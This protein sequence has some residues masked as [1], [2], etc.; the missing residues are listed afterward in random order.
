[1]NGHLIVSV[2]FALTLVSHIT[3]AA[4]LTKVNDTKVIT[5][6]TST[7]QSIDSSSEADDLYYDI[8]EEKD[9]LVAEKEFITI[10]CINSALNG[11]SP[12]ITSTAGVSKMQTVSDLKEWYCSLNTSVDVNYRKLQKINSVCRNEISEDL[13]TLVSDCESQEDS[14]LTHVDICEK[15]N[16]ET[17]KTRFAVINCTVQV[18][19]NDGVECIKRTLKV[20][21]VPNNHTVFADW[22]C[23]TYNA[24]SQYTF[25]VAYTEECD[26][27][28]E[29]FIDK[30]E[31][32]A[33]KY[34]QQSH[35]DDD[36]DD[37]ANDEPIAIE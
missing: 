6:T 9:T 22:Y 24:T 1:M 3:G 28:D 37:D 4:V 12:C 26:F 10:K 19:G 23:S 8:C 21:S 2:T 17:A 31:S 33:E 25:D 7:A 27:S 11:T 35:D 32:C 5:V 14:R 18:A 13:E 29:T 20:S 15:K 36:D 16:E 34:S 30:I